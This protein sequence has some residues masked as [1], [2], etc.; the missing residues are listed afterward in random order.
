MLFRKPFQR[1]RL[2]W[3]V[4]RAPV[5]ELW[6]PSIILHYR[7]IE[8]VGRPGFGGNTEASAAP[9]SETGLL[10]QPHGALGLNGFYCLK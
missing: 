3:R 5:I 6:S 9:D 10:M 8:A 2:R 7:E 1:C 4:H